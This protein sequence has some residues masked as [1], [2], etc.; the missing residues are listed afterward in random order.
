MPSE[1]FSFGDMYIY[2]KA[3]QRLNK[4]RCYENKNMIL[5]ATII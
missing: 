5:K 3:S 1:F 4:E 2:I